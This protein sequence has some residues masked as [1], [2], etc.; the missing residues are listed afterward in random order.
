MVDS[1]GQQTSRTAKNE[2]HRH[3]RIT[4]AGGLAH[5]SGG[6]GPQKVA[7]VGGRL[8]ADGVDVVVGSKR[9]VTRVVTHS[10]DLR[11]A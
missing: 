2:A 11:Y 1:S 9:L 5:A 8:A 6:L 4:H 3:F 10:I 7:G